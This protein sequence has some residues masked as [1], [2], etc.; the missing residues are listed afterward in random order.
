MPPSYIRS[1]DQLEL[2]QALE[3]TPSRGVAR[4]D[5]GVEAGLDQLDAATAEARSARRRDRFSVSSLKLVSITPALR[6]QIAAA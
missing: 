5:Q 3:V 2:V 6:R 4:I 1:T